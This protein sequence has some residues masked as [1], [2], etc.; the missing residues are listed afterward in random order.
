MEAVNFNR[1]R[2][3]VRWVHNR[4]VVVVDFADDFAEALRI[5]TKALLAGK[6]DV[7]LRSRNMGTPPPMRLRPYYKKPKRKDEEGKRVEPLAR[8]NLS[9]WLWCPYCIHL[10]KF[11][12]RNGFT[13]EGHW[14]PEPQYECQMCGITHRDGTV[15]KWNPVARRW[16]DEGV[17]ARR[18]RKRAHA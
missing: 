15:Q 13:S 6:S 9:G 11:V 3:E 10:R 8:Y 14:V 18:K 2:W 17:R 16:R 12:H 1:A 5:F 7:T 4:R